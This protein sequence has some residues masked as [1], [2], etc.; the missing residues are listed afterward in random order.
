VAID[1]ALVGTLDDQFD[2]D[3]GRSTRMKPGRWEHRSVLQRVAE[4]A[5]API[6]R[7]F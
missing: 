3:L 2:E 6:K 5:V 7:F 1:R 4:A